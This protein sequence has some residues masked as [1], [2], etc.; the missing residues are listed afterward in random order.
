MTNE[1]L[2]LEKVQAATNLLLEIMVLLP[3]PSPTVHKLRVVWNSETQTEAPLPRA[4]GR[5]EAVR[6]RREQIREDNDF[7][8]ALARKKALA[9]AQNEGDVLTTPKESQMLIPIYIPGV[10]VSEKRR[11]DGRYQG[12]AVREGKKYFFYGKTYEELIR[13][14]SKFVQEGEIERR[15]LVETSPKFGEYIRKWIENYKKPNLKPSSFQ[16][17]TAALRPALEAFENKKLRLITSDEIQELLVGMKAKRMRDMCKIYL[18]EAFQKA[19]DKGELKRNHCAAVEIKKH[20]S[21]HKNALTV[22]EQEL[23]CAAVAGTEYELLCLFLLATGLRIGEALALLRSDFDF[24]KHTV[25]V[26]KNVVYIKGERIEQD[27]PKS[28]AGNRTVPVP[29]HLCERLRD[30]QTDLIF[31]YHAEAVRSFMKRLRKAIDVD[32]TPHILRHTYATRL[33]EAGVPPKIKQYLMGHASLEMTENVYTDAQKRYIDSVSDLVRSVFNP[34]NGD[35][36]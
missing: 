29:V 3:S 10:S 4:I 7:C 16:S 8:A 33:S 5:E 2:I 34:K 14:I 9:A 18:N 25:T 27:T 21:E 31:P 23:F 6:L 30:V 28:E 20:R 1:T 15:K 19:V 32:V 12:Y 17:L 11:K 26:S 24:E 36:T 22:D 35:L 13:K